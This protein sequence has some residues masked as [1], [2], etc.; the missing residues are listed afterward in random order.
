MVSKMQ[1]GIRGVNVGL[2]MDA[3]VFFFFWCVSMFYLRCFD[4]VVLKAVGR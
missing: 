4:N 2:N 1:H 3:M